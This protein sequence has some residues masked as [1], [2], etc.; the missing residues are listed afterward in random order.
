VKNNKYNRF[1]KL[2]NI[3]SNKKNTWPVDA[4]VYIGHLPH[5]FY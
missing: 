2:D 5:G 4:V 1:D 3:D